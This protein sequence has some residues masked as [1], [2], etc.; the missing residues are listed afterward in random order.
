MLRV[1]T[2][3]VHDCIG[4][5]GRHDVHRTAAVLAEL[6]A[7]VLALQ[8]VTVDDAG[9]L[10]QVFAATTAMQVIDGSLFG[11][12]AGRYGNLLLTRYPVREMRLHDLSVAGREPRGF[13]Q[14][15]LD[16]GGSKLTVFATHLGLGWRER[17]VQVCRLAQLTSDVRG[18]CVILGDLNSWMGAW[19]FRPL[20]PAGFAGPAIRS[21]PTWPGP[22][23]ALDR[24]L[25]R[26][27]ATIKR[28][29]RHDGGMAR[30]AS[31]HFP[32][33]AD[34]QPIG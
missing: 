27:P 7:D 33:V 32:V 25:V 1:A 28:C 18:P 17:R 14:A 16:C 10:A 3:N 20:R 23:L 2:F 4:R 9:Q 21:F 15:D 13:I 11:R 26:P 12:G 30:M 8:E 24:I 31:D 29:W 6:E 19:G 34:I 22:L 5:D